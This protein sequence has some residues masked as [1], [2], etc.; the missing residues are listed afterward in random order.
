MIARM[1]TPRTWDIFCRVID[2]HG[3][4]G[5]C[6][7]LAAQLGA[8]GQAVRLWID[9]PAPLAWMAPEGAS[10]V[11]VRPWREPFDAQGLVPGEVWIEA[12]GC[13]LPESFVAA[14]TGEPVWINLEYLSAEAW[15]ER[16]HGLP[17]PVMSGPGRG[18][19]KR[20][21]YP[22]F[23]ARTGG[24]LRED[25]LAS[26]Q[27]AFDRGA[28][29]T[30]QGLPAQGRRIALFCYEPPSLPAM[31]AQA[32]AHWLVTRGRAAAAAMDLPLA[33]GATRHALP[34][35]SQRGFDE[36]LWSADLNLVR[37]EDS[38]VRALWAGQPFV[39]QIYPQHDGAHHAK[40]QAF[41]D[42]LDA[43]ASLRAFHHHWNGLPGAPAAAA[44][45]GWAEVDGWREV[46]QAA[47]QRLLAQP[48]LATQLAE[49]VGRK[50]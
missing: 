22:G 48:D 41:L 9:D 35:L 10:G 36:L 31:M 23:T 16:C 3:D 24:L 46:V 49:A 19:T 33:P 32:E 26:R 50:R 20:F 47:R 38:L 12:F 7:R 8:R 18:L 5:V 28:W 11:S 15:V 40:L 17:S 14:R 42:W 6:W 30:A 29:L 13:E 27:A 39:W 2:N 25:D 21:F 45:P 43:P 44:W 34:W 4:A 37:G 1:S